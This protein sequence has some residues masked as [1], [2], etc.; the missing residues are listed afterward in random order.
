M[1]MPTS[2]RIDADAGSTLVNIRWWNELRDPL[3]SEYIQIALENNK[4]LQ[5]AIWRVREFYAQYQI[6]RSSLFPQINLEGSALRERFPEGVSFLP[7]NF[8]PVTDEYSYSFNL[9]YEIDFWGKFRNASS[10]AYYEYLAQVENRRTVVLTLVGAVAQAYIF[11]RDLDLQL[12]ISQ[13]TLESRKESL[14]IARDRFEGGLTSEIEVAQAASAYEEALAAVVV[15][16]R[17]IP[18]QENLLSILLGQAPA[19]IA[20]GKDIEQLMLPCEVPSGLPSDL[21]TR[22]PD[23]MQAENLLIAANANIGVAR[24]AFFPQISLTGA[25]GGD[26]FEL[27]ELFSNPARMWQI[28]ANL[29]QAIFT[30]GAL[31]GQ[32]DVAKAQRQEACFQYQQTILN[33]LREVND[34]LIAYQKTRELVRVNEADVAALKDYLYLAWLRY[35]EGETQYLTVLD[36]ERQL[37]TAEIELAQSEGDQFLTLVDLYKAL[38]GGWVIEADN[39][40]L[41]SEAKNAN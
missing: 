24:A 9:S 12:K 17:S 29:L 4:E 2:W 22:R 39:F 19:D 28:G 26:S 10:T 33:A 6:V 40:S 41:S 11:L 14:R 15:L 7:P 21:L 20:R 18:Q 36:A 3:L 25:Y 38:G 8:N 16:E 32:L 37:F 1:E 27:H 13:L 31:I 35:Y 34:A 23:I 5:V 30:G